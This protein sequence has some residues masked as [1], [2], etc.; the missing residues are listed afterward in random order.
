MVLLKPLPFQILILPIFHR[1]KSGYKSEKLWPFASWIL[2]FISFMRFSF[3]RVEDWF[4]YWS[5]EK[6]V[7]GQKQFRH[8]I[9]PGKAREPQRS[10]ASSTLRWNRF[11]MSTFIFKKF[12]TRSSTFKETETLGKI[13]NI[14]PNK[15]ICTSLEKSTYKKHT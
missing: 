7:K 8:L 10:M 14:V 9:G 13:F 4:W 6:Y 1:F 15:K 3:P 2:Y 11:W 12:S 5:L